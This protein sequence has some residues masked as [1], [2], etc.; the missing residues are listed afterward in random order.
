VDC[1]GLAQG[2]LI[3]S[4]EASGLQKGGYARP[5]EGPVIG[6]DLYLASHQGNVDEN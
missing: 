5:R 3:E 2:L 4:I 6:Y 1:N